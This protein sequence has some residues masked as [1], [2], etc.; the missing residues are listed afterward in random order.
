M[1]IEKFINKL[2][3]AINLF[4]EQ[5]E[6]LN[7]INRGLMTDKLELLLDI[8]YQ[9][10]KIFE[11]G[12]RVKVTNNNGY[13]T[14]GIV[15]DCELLN[16]TPNKKD[17]IW[18]YQVNGEWYKSEQLELAKPQDIIISD[19]V[20]THNNSYIVELVGTNF[21]DL[22]SRLISKNKIYLL[23]TTPE[24][25]LKNQFTT[26]S[27]N[28]LYNCEWILGRDINNKYIITSTNML[29]RRSHFKNY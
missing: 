27:E 13:N 16:D 17:I 15:M 29:L 25:W 10:I 20:F 26:F 18:M 3:D 9:P 2:D 23:G 12:N 28:S 24:K 4:N 1:N 22:I 6:K 7:E 11:F 14:S 21:Y 19:T 5:P 8:V